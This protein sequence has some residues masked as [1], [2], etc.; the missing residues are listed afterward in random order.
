[1]WTDHRSR[2]LK[3]F[4]CAAVLGILAHGSSAQDAVIRGAVVSED[5]SDP[6]GGV[7]VYISQ[8]TWGSST[9]DDGGFEITSIPPGEYEVVATMIGFG[10]RSQVVEVIP[11]KRVYEVR[12]ALPA[13]VLELDEIEI[14]TERPRRWERNLRRFIDHFIGSSDNA[15]A[16]TIVNPYVLD[17]ETTGPDLYARASAPLVIENRA[18]GYKLHFNLRRYTQSDQLLQMLWQIR[19]EE[20]EPADELERVRW[21]EARQK[22][23]EGSLMHFLRSLVRGTHR[24]DGFDAQ[25]RLR[26][27]DRIDWVQVGAFPILEVTERPYVYRFFFEDELYVSY[28][29]EESGMTLAEGEVLVHRNGYVYG[30]TILEPLIMVAGAMAGDR[31]AD[32][33]PLN[34]GL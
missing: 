16:T 29:R 4:V 1:M 13:A 26:R 21:E 18:L 24:E 14:E 23:Y 27:T 33:L 3:R 5:T 8:T 34:Y 12:F 31:V 6:L 11:E 28:G 7:N 19:F 32:L 22:A 15:A 30:S 2:V 10:T 20:I 25:H 9:S 17:F